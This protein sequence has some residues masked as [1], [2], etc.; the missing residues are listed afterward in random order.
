MGCTQMQS[1]SH[2]S[3]AMPKQ[4]YVKLYNLDTNEYGKTVAIPLTPTE[5]EEQ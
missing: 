5:S 2:T 4:L 1:R 3:E